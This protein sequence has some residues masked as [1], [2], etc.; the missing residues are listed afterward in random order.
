MAV[1]RKSIANPK[2]VPL[3]FQKMY[4]LCRN[5]TLTNTIIKCR[6]C[7]RTEYTVKEGFSVEGVSLNVV[8]LGASKFKWNEKSHQELKICHV[9]LQT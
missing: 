2:N 7:N 4:Q 8:P 3:L 6:L 9:P 5:G 1:V